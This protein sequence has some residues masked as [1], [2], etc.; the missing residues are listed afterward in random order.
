MRPTRFPATS[1]FLPPEP[2]HQ[3][4]PGVG[5]PRIRAGI[6]LSR[7]PYGAR[8]HPQW[9][10]RE[11]A[12]ARQIVGAQ[13]SGDRRLIAIAPDLSGRRVRLVRRIPPD[14]ARQRL[15]AG[16]GHRQIYALRHRHTER[17]PRLEPSRGVLRTITRQRL[18]RPAQ[19]VG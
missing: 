8:R 2:I 14:A 12:H 10:L 17:L 4:N 11:P 1:R 6:H 15:P 13:R 3:A 19:A 9:R 18:E 16:G 5:W 7:D